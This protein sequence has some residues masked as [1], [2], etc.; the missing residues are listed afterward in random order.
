MRRR[1]SQILPRVRSI[2]A[3]QC[4]KA[5]R[6]RS[7]LG[8]RPKNMQ[9]FMNTCAT[10]AKIASSSVDCCCHSHYT[11]SSATSWQSIMEPVA[12]FL[13]P[14]TQAFILPKTS[15]YKNVEEVI[16]SGFMT[17]VCIRHQFL[18]YVCCK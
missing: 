9:I 12:V 4:A 15:V 13:P 1:G 16:R 6:T 3:E 18:N 11:T 10:E 2:G 8:K 17:A 7:G 5:A 14:A